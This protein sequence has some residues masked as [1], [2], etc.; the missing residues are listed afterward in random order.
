[1]ARPPQPV[2]P[3]APRA[4]SPSVAGSASSPAP[5]AVPQRADK[6]AK[7]G[8]ALALRKDPAVSHAPASPQA[9]LE[10]F[11]KNL[12]ELRA[13][14]EL[15]YPEMEE[16][17]HYTMKTLASA[18]GGL[19]LPTLPVTTA[20]VR[21]CGGNVA[22]W[23]DRWRQLA[24]MIEP[25]GDRAL[26]QPEHAHADV[27]GAASSGAGRGERDEKQGRDA[28]SAGDASSQEHLPP[29]RPSSQ[30]SSSPGPQGPPG[31][32]GEE[33]VYVITSAAPRHPYR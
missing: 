29:Q 10:E 17:S 13:K 33:Q 8:T 2:S 11:A 14:A 16:L 9:A 25:K 24:E 15:G 7:P 28:A 30:R 20:Y 19:R 23:E 18:A 21:A 31:P 32:P 27:L 12:R 5:A 6:P 1:M 3:S 4:A 26:P 22:D